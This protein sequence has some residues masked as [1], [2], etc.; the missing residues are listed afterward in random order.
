MPHRAC[1][2][3]KSSVGKID[4]RFARMRCLRLGDNADCRGFAISAF[5]PGAVEHASAKSLPTVSL[6]VSGLGSQGDVA[7]WF[8][9]FIIQKSSLIR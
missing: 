3:L 6:R 1:R 4:F 7:N 9:T 5:F 8:E 2:V